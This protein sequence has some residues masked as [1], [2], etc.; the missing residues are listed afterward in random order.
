MSNKQAPPAYGGQYPPPQQQQQAYGAGAYP[1]AQGAYHGPPHGFVQ[2][3]AYGNPQQHPPQYQQQYYPQ[4]TPPQDYAG[5]PPQ[6]QQY[7]QPPPAPQMHYPPPHQQQQQQQQQQHQQYQRPQVAP[8]PSGP[9]LGGGGGAGHADLDQPPAC[10]D[11]ICATIFLGQLVAV[12]VL[13]AFWLRKST[14]KAS[15]AGVQPGFDYDQWSSVVSLGIQ[16]FVISLAVGVGLALCCLR[17][18][19]ALEGSVVMLSIGVH[20]AVY[21]IGAIILLAYGLTGGIVLFFCAAL[22]ALFVC[23]YRNRIPFAEAVL[24]VT[25]SS[26]RTFWGTKVVGVVV[27]LAGLAWMLFW[28][29][30]LVAA[31]YYVREGSVGVVVFFA[32]FHLYWTM[33]TCRNVGFT[34]TAGAVGSW[35]YLPGAAEGVTS[36]ALKRASTTSLGSIALGSF[37]VAV[38]EFIR[39]LLRSASRRQNI[40]ACIALCLLSCIESLIRYFNMYAYTQVALY[41]KDFVSA[42]KDTWDLF[43][44]RGATMIINDNLLGFVIGSASMICSVATCIIIG[45]PYFFKLDDDLRARGISD[46]GSWASLAPISAFVLGAIGSSAIIAVLR[47]GSVTTLTVYC[48]D[49]NALQL[50]RPEEYRKLNNAFANFPRD[51]EEAN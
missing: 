17:A 48:E 9:A 11:K 42:A 6:Q 47:S 26:V 24:S 14:A 45:V 32:L 25:L 23:C 46:H 1:Q 5:P 43:Q 30:S 19:Q 8:A 12:I 41:G 7:F 13:G 27:A 49:P 3:A 22:C 10:R 29:A 51:E 40:L 28:A 20:M 4:Q 44:A 37:I 18:M 15:N 39:A 31:V 33:E 34:A 2:P 35:W 21:V 50:T 36:G 16:I 38:L